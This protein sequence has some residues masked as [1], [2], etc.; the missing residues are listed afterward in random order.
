MF[1]PWTSPLETLRSASWATRLLAVF[2]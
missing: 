2:Q 1:E